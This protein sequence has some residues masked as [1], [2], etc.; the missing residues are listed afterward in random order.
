[1]DRHDLPADE[2]PSTALT[3]LLD[4]VEAVVVV[5]GSHS[6]NTRRL[7]DRCRQRGLAAFHV[8]DATELDPDWFLGYETIGLT[9]GTS[10]LAETIEQVHDRLLSIASQPKTLAL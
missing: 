6:H 8:Q 5:G 10:T 4:Q 3:D 9:A 1:M 2:R 7:V